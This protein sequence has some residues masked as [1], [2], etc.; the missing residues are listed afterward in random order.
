MANGCTYSICCPSSP[1]RQ[2]RQGI[3]G[4]CKTGIIE[5][6]LCV[7]RLPPIEQ[8]F[9]II[10]QAEIQQQICAL[11]LAGSKP[12]QRGASHMDC[13]IETVF[14]RPDTVV[15]PLRQLTERNVLAHD[16]FDRPSP[17]VIH[18]I[19]AVAVD[20]VIATTVDAA[21]E[22]AVLRDRDG[23]ADLGRDLD[24]EFA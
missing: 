15:R 4:I 17:I 9:K 7:R 3:I 18:W 22:S 19:G 21:N 5:Q 24:E 20:P 14:W 10:G 23:V 8:T 11:A 16:I 6:D 1:S 2:S 12:D 13:P